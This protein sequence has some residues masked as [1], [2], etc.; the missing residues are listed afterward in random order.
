MQDFTRKSLLGMYET[1][2]NWLGDIEPEVI[3]DGHVR[4]LV[5]VPQK[6][7]NYFGNAF[8]GFLMSLVDVH[9][10]AVP[11]TRGKYVVT[12]TCDVHFVKGVRVG[13]TILIEASDVHTGRTSSIADVRITG[14]EKDDLRLS[15]TVTMHIVGDI[16]QDDPDPSIDGT[17]SDVLE[18]Y[19]KARS[20][21]EPQAT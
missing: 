20:E 19:M 5:K 2:R 9:G 14:S 7:G 13:E 8:G 17:E 6:A 4:S 18:R 15:A 21:T 10:C 3:E 12:Q 1:N 16:S 11:W